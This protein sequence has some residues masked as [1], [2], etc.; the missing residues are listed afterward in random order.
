MSKLQK[1]FSH[2]LFRL[3]NAQRM[4]TQRIYRFF[5]RLDVFN[6]VGDDFIAKR[7]IVLIVLQQIARDVLVARV[8]DYVFSAH[9]FAR[10]HHEH[11]DCRHYAVGFKRKHVEIEILWQRTDLLSD[12]FVEKFE[13]VAI[14]ERNFE[15][16]LCGKLFHLFGERALDLFVVAF[17]KVNDFL[18]LGLVFLLS[19]LSCARSKASAKVHI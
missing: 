6:V 5:E 14:V 17:Q 15:I 2:P 18:H 11:T 3:D 1:L 12:K 9:E 13:L 10:T 7:S 8:D 19:Y 16:L 4:R